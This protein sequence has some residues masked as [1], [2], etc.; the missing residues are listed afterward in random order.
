MNP[1]L[2]ILAAGAGSRY[3]RLKQLDGMGPNDEVLFEYSVYDALTAG[4]GRVVF[5]INRR[6]EGRFRSFVED[7]FTDRIKTDFVYQ[8]L[9]SCTFGQKCATARVKPWGTGHAV[10][11]A[12]EI[13]DESFLMINADDFY[14]REAFQLA[15]QSFAGNED[16]FVIG[17]PVGKT[18]SSHGTVNRAELRMNSQGDLVE[19]A[20]RLNVWREKGNVYYKENEKILKLTG[21]D[22][23]ISMNIMGFPGWIFPELQIRF[24]QFLEIN[25]RNPDAEF[26]MPNIVNEILKEK[27]ST[28]KVIKTNADWFGVTFPEDREPAQKKMAG[29]IRQGV[30]PEKLWL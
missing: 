14:G 23:P 7:K 6:I 18:L 8:E 11:C 29:L 25:S 3:G 9:D 5:V 4:F 22:A 10:L 19:I 17:Y 20:E 15:A 24:N 26:L 13:I 21:P 16:F 12:G 30:Y 1:T 27:G 2:L 28:V